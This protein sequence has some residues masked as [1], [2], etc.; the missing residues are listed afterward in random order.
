MK[1][2]TPI[3]SECPFCSIA[4]LSPTSPSA[5]QPNNVFLNTPLVIGFLDIQPLVSSTGAHLLVTPRYHYETLDQVPDKIAREMGSALALSVNAL[6]RVLRKL[7]KTPENEQE[8]EHEQEVNVN[9]IQNN[10]SGAGQVVPHVHFHIVARPSSDHQTRF[11]AKSL[12]PALGRVFALEK[13]IDWSLWQ[14]RLSYAAQ[15]YGRGQRED[16]DD[17]WCAEFVPRLKLEMEKL[18]PRL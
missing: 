16:L 12:K 18:R 5:E 3:S 6:K 13:E 8:Q 1:T 4:T 17:D 9:V 2:A 15:I 11:L 14:N 7:N 10:G